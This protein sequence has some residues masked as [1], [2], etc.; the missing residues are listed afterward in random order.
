MSRQTPENGTGAPVEAETQVA[1]GTPQSQRLTR[2]QG[3][4]RLVLA[5]L[6][7]AENAEDDMARSGIVLDLTVQGTRCLLIRS[8]G[9]SAVAILSPREREIARMVA[10]GLTNK[11]IACVL[12]ISPWTVSTHLRRIF[13]KLRV[14][15]RAAMVARLAMWKPAPHETPWSDTFPTIPARGVGQ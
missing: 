14:S 15:S 11:S 9:P 8:D 6:E 2:P 5:L 10:A 4:E 1:F 3:L 7:G 12:E 13:T